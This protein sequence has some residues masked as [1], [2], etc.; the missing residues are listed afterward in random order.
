M[1]KEQGLLDS[2]IIESILIKFNLSPIN[3]FNTQLE[4]EKHKEFK[5]CIFNCD[6]DFS[7]Q[8]FD[9]EI[10]FN[11][12]IFLGNVNFSNVV[13][14]NNVYFKEVR[15]LNYQDYT[16]TTIVDKKRL[17][18]CFSNA[19]FNQIA[20]F[21][22][23]SFHNFVNFIGVKFNFKFN[24]N[25][26]EIAGKS[27]YQSCSFYKSQFE[28]DCNFSLSCFNGPTSF[29]S[30]NF[31]KKAIFL[32]AI[33]F[34]SVGFD[35]DV[36]NKNKKS[37]ESIDLILT[38]TI[39]K[40]KAVFYHR[41]FSNILLTNTRFE[42]LADFYDVTFN[43]D[44]HFY[45]TDFLDT[46]VFS[47]CLFKKKAI[48]HYT[49]IANN[50]IL[51][52]ANF[53]G[54]L[55]LALLNFTDNGYLNTFDLKISKFKSNINIE[56]VDENTD[57]WK[58]IS[59]IDKRE[60]YRILKNE[61]IR[62]NNRIEA[63]KWHKYE[64]ASYKD[65]I[66]NRKRNIDFNLIKIP[67]NLTKEYFTKSC[68]LTIKYILALSIEERIILFFYKWT[69][70][71]GQSWSL[72]ILFTLVVGSLFFAV[73]I[74]VLF[75][76]QIDLSL[77]GITE[78]YSITINYIEYLPR[79]INPTHSFDFIKESN[80]CPLILDFCA[81]IFVGLGIYQTIQAFRRYGRL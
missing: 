53:Q 21:E 25:D 22:N 4:I 57:S 28:D 9:D 50:V 68:K 79:F 55:N 71:Y 77:K 70:Y 63:L 24:F 14:N 81:R 47:K 38:D 52:G 67:I 62:Q 44:V 42:S 15:F 31:K 49:K 41:L 17:N 74:P 32:S 27:L 43:A 37:R 26:I 13:F 39:F 19:I 16:N 36:I 56:G 78:W 34:D 60:T 45:K 1:Y 66:K 18:I 73:Y 61:S 29:S 11:D 6:I 51:R 75:K 40:K 76:Y 54:G 33:F 23:S 59:M 58:N 3:I 35:I 2:N 72:G 8:Q 20:I 46:C 7:E 10:I 65:E 5:K 80:G 12:S 30:T 64:M 48:F 69:N